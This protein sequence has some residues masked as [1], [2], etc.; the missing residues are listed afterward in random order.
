MPETTTNTSGRCCVNP[1][2]K[3]EEILREFGFEVAR[4]SFADISQ[5]DE[6][7]YLGDLE[8]LPE[9]ESSRLLLAFPDLFAIHPKAE[10]ESGTF[11]VALADADEEKVAAARRILDQY[12]LGR[13]ALVEY[14]AENSF[15]ARWHRD[16]EN[17]LSLADFLQRAIDG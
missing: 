9:C 16:A 10:P 17:L 15:T 6:T 8:E 13:V 1:R 12:F 2:E 3:L 11:F 14:K 7:A 4:T 5:R